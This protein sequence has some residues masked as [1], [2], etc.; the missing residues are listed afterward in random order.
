[1]TTVAQPTTP[2]RTIK[3]YAQQGKQ[4]VADRVRLARDF[5]KDALLAVFPPRDDTQEEETGGFFQAFLQVVLWLA[6]AAFLLASLPHVAYFFASFEPQNTDGTVS[7]YWWFVAYALAVSIDVTAFLLSLNVAIK[8][9]KATASLPWYQKIVPALLVLITHWPFILLLVGFSWLVNFEHAKEFHS[10]MLAGAETV[11]INLLFWRGTLGDLNPVIASAFP[12]LAVAYTG[13]S[14]Q[15]GDQRKTKRT[16]QQQAI[17]V[18]PVTVTQMASAAQPA[19]V[20]PP[21]L[22]VSAPDWQTVLQS[23]QEMNLQ[24]L[25]T[26]QAMNQQNMQVTVEQFTKVTVEAMREVVEQVVVALPAGTTPAQIEAPK[27]ASGSVNPPN[28]VPSD[29]DQKPVVG[30]RASNKSPYAD[31]IEAL[32]KDNPTITTAEIVRQVGCSKPIALKWLHKVRPLTETEQ[33]EAI[34]TT[35]VNVVE[36]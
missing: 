6:F 28:L 15:I 4:F 9:R 30:L 17:P 18:N 20:L 12:V 21:P 25:K 7:D 5:S 32:Y 31:Q 26:M 14:D 33:L 2:K 11:T 36:E 3:D 19:Q 16:Q 13:M 34:H 29:E 23:M 1:M 8:M 24:T 35:T 27:E 10:Q 22:T